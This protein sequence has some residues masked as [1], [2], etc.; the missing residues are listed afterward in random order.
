MAQPASLESQYSRDVTLAGERAEPLRGTNATFNNDGD[1]AQLTPGYIAKI[2]QTH[3]EV[4]D[5][6]RRRFVPEWLKGFNQYHGDYEDRGKA[7]WQNNVHIP[8]PKQA[9]DTSA[10]RIINAVFANNEDFFDISPFTRQQ[11]LIVSFAK[12]C[13][14]WQLWKSDAREAVTTAVKDALICGNGPMKVYFDATIT[15]T[16][17]VDYGEP[18]EPTPFTRGQQQ[19]QLKFVDFSEVIRRLRLEPVIPTDFW[20][21]PS[22]RGEWVIQRVKRT[23]SDVWAL[24]RDQKDPQ[25]GEVLIPAVY[26][27]EQV[28]MLRVGHGDQRS[29]IEAAV[30]RRDT[31]HLHEDTAI[32]LY[33]FWGDLKDPTTGAILFKNIVATFAEKQWCIRYPTPNMFRHKMAPFIMFRPEE[34]PHQVY[35][36][37]LLQPSSRIHDAMVRHTNIV[38]DKLLLTVPCVEIDPLAARNPEE[39]MGDKVHYFPGKTFQRKSAERQIFYPVQGFEPPTEVD[40]MMLDKLS[41]FYD[42]GTAVNEFVTGQTV[43]TNRKT[44]EEV[45]A[46]TQAAQTTFNSAAEFIENNAL[47]PLL[48]MIYYLVIQFIDDYDD[49][50]L[51]KMFGDDPGARDFALSLKGLSDEER[52]KAMYLDAEFRVTGITNTITRQDRLNRIMGWLKSIQAYPQLMALVDLRGLQRF[53]MLNFDVPKELLLPQADALMQAIEQQ[54]LQQLMQPPQPDQGQPQQGQTML[55]DNQHNQMAGAAGQFNNAPP[56]Q[57]GEM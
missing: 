20:I 24:A 29:N 37:G 32:E 28:S 34:Q 25:T 31:P 55:G 4:A 42:M 36:Y 3:F 43:T 51:L 46:R 7:P 30:I 35:G 11:D 17:G 22:G 49:E 45:Q 14:K 52:W 6:Y 2:F 40:L 41:F 10:A 38:L 26:D 56:E 5:T 9:V 12:A 47:S 21:D 54:Q 23:L 39:L 48:K 1:K 53:L 8:K 44:K 19:G 57:T 18:P 16:T 15:T 13:I 27:P 33:E 50:T